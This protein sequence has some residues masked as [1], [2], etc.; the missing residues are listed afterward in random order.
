MKICLLIFF[1]VFRNSDI[2]KI[3]TTKPFFEYCLNIEYQML[4]MNF[5]T[6]NLVKNHLDKMNML[7]NLPVYFAIF[8]LFYC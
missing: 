4:V 6:F 5:Q 7:T 3:D 2:L 8:G 1:E